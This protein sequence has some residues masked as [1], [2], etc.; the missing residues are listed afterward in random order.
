MKKFA[1]F[2]LIACVCWPLSVLASSTLTPAQ[3]K[4]AHRLAQRDHF[5]EQQVLV[6]LAKS[7][8]S[9]NVL[10]KTKH[11]A[12]D[13]PWEFYRHL[14]VS[15]QN[16]RGGAAYYKKH[17]QTLQQ[18][19]QRYGVDPLAIVAIVGMESHFGAHQGQHQA[20]T[21]LNTLAFYGRPK[22]QRLFQE[23][24]RALFLLSRKLG[25]DPLSF[26]SS[27]SGA[28]GQPQFMPTTYLH[29]AAS[30]HKQSKLPDLFHHDEDVI[31]SV[32]N[33]LAKAGWKKDEAIAIETQQGKQQMLQYVEKG[34]NKRWHK[35]SNF[36]AVHRYNQSNKY[37]LAVSE[38]ANE[39]RQQ[40]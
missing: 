2:S 20:A 16:I 13:K 1:L 25:A 26:K 36:K 3:K 4:F 19:Y 10:Y 5:N 35:S 22:R 12:E 24:L 31:F 21:A 8:P 37:V 15:Q 11:P 40:L 17:R 30:P 33:Y 34:K 23:Q 6:W 38:L 39:I 9:Q 18:A 28:L 29:Y 32:A 27:Y 7:S 14:F